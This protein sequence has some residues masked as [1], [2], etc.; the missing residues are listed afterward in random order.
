MMIIPLPNLMSVNSK[1]GPQ[2]SYSGW[3]WSASS[4]S[5]ETIKHT[6][7][8]HELLPDENRQVHVHVD[9]F[10]MGLGGYDSWSPNVTEKYLFRNRDPVSVDV[11]LIPIIAMK[12]KG[13]CSSDIV[14]LAKEVYA[15][16]MS[17]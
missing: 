13:T 15:E 10:T 14:S 1:T 12:N 17:K 2:E 7:H 9:S 11:M 8:D 4:S 16:V 6:S 3:G 5:L